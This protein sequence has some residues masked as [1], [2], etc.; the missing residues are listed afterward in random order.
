MLQYDSTVH[1][2]GT[3]ALSATTPAVEITAAASQ[4]YSQLGLGSIAT[5]VLTGVTN[6]GIYFSNQT[7]AFTGGA[8]STITFT[9][10]YLTLT[11]TV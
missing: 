6:K 10:Q 9:I 5:T 8:G 3:V 2:A 1:G 7:G 4:I 11:A